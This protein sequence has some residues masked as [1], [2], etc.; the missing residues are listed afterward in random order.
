MYITDL[1]LVHW[2]LKKLK[3]TVTHHGGWLISEEHSLT[4]RQ[5]NGEQ[6]LELWVEPKEIVV[7]EVFII[8]E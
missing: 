8:L 7:R 1:T 3:F 4:Y 5:I 6:C 2:T